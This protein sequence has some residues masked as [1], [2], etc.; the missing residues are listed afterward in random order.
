MLMLDGAH[1]SFKKLKLELDS[2]Y[3]KGSDTY[4][5]D[6]NAVLR[7]LNQRQPSRPSA[8]V[9]KH[10]QRDRET[11][12]GL[13]FAQS[14]G[15]GNRGG[16]PD[17][18][19]CFRCGKKGHISVD[20]TEEKPKGKD[21]DQI[22]SMDGEEEEDLHA[23]ADQE[24]ADD[25]DGDDEAVYFFNQYSGVGGL[26]PDWLLLDSQ[27]STDMFCNAEH[28][29][30]IR[31][32]A[33][34]TNIRC[35]AGVKRVTQEADFDGFDDRIVVKYDPQG[36]CNV[37]SFKT[38]KK[39]YPITYKSHP[40]DGG[41]AAFEV[42]TPRGVVEFKPCQKGLHYLDMSV[43][44]NKEIMFAQSVVPTIRKNF[45][46]FTKREIHRAIQARKLQSMIGSPGKA[47]YE[48]MVREKLIDDC[49]VD[50]DD[51]KNAQKIFGPADLAGLRGKTVRRRPERVEVKIV[52]FPRDFWLC[53]STAC[54]W[55][56][57]CSS[58]ERRSCSLVREEYS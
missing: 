17:N 48:G 46:G 55:Q 35:N 4:P 57:S 39:L 11:S 25:V 29:N 22:H 32:A 30:N 38:M 34:V 2:D 50:T 8:W 42:H 54:L 14:S 31:R 40:D 36:I 58:M 44:R 41:T 45:E 20:C 13:M 53:T 23:M 10:L 52:A 21:D 49:P 5:T 12:D 7:L 37:V 19:T 16:R 15:G 6:R 3:A 43:Q 1:D 28:I 26:N 33:K 27:S 51:L 56:M 18:R 9:P 47:D 24:A